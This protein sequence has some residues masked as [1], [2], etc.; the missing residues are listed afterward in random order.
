MTKM[1]M[2]IYKTKNIGNGFSA[3]NADKK[4]AIKNDRKNVSEK[5]VKQMEQILSRMQLNVEYKVEEVAEWLNVGRAR[6]RTLLKMTEIE[7]T[8]YQWE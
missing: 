2:L 8:K 4:T 5:T 1:V 3:K 6:A 7:I